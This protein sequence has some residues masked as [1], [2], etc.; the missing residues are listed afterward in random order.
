MLYV[1]SE[2]STAIQAEIINS[3]SLTEVMIYNYHEFQEA[4][5]RGLSQIRIHGAMAKML[6][7]KELEWLSHLVKY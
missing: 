3:K 1:F 6:D 2:K 7:L 4:H 5:S